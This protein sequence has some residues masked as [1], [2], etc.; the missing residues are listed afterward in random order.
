MKTLEGPAWSA[1]GLEPAGGRYPLSVER[2][3]MRMADLLVPGVT[4]GTPHARYYALH[5]LIAIGV[6]RR[7]LDEEQTQ[8]LL[9]RRA[10][11]VVA[12]VSLLHSHDQGIG[13]P[14]A[15]GP[16]A[17]A[18]SVS[19]GDVTM[20]TASLPEKPGYVR[21]AWG[22]WPPYAASEVT[23]GIDSSASDV[24]MQESAPSGPSWRDNESFFLGGDGVGIELGS[25][26][27]GWA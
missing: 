20:T 11:V 18:R 22:F 26:W 10:E 25:S 14:R 9:L 16:D 15:H 4:T 23:L 17:L 7:G 5:G 3:V 8:D 2:H 19:A 12:A 24:D 13:L 21:N 27:G 1:E 6:A